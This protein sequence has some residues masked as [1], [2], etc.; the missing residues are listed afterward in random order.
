MIFYSFFSTISIYRSCWVQLRSIK[1][2]SKRSSDLQLVLGLLVYFQNMT[3]GHLVAA[4]E[5]M[6]DTSLE[7]WITDCEESDNSS[8]DDSSISRSDFSTCTQCK[9]LNVNPQYRYCE[10]CYQVDISTELHSGCVAYKM[11]LN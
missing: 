4:A 7:K 11:A 8:L 1:T 5:A 10:K 6:Y 9:S 2:F 3:L